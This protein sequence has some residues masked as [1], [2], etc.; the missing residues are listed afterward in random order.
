MIQSKVWF[1]NNWVLF[2][3]NINTYQN[4]ITFLESNGLSFLTTM[5]LDFNTIPFVLHGKGNSKNLLEYLGNNTDNAIL[6]KQ[7]L[8]YF[9]TDIVIMKY[10][11]SGEKINFEFLDNSWQDMSMLVY[12]PY[13]PTTTTTTTSGGNFIMTIDMLNYI[14][15]KNGDY[16][17]Y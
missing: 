17:T 15:T 12:G 13:I 11:L 3:L 16:I 14:V 2:S 5:S 8:V 7:F 6:I 4:I 10:Y 1:N 9:I